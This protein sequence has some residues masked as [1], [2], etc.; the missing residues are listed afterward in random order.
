MARQKGRRRRLPPPSFFARTPRPRVNGPVLPDE[1]VDAKLELYRNGD[2]GFCYNNDVKKI[3]KAVVAAA[4][5]TIGWSAQAGF[6]RPQ[7]TR[8]YLHGPLSERVAV[9]FREGKL[10]L[11]ENIHRDD[12]DA[13][14]Y[15]K[16]TQPAHG[17]WLVHGADD[18]AFDFR[19]AVLNRD[20]DG[21]PVHSQIWR[22]GD[23]EVE[24]AACMPVGLRTSIQA[25]LTVTNR[26]TTPQAESFGFLLRAAPENKLVFGAP[27]IY[28]IYAPDVRDWRQLPSTFRSGA[29][30]TFVDGDR[31]AAFG[32]VPRWDAQ[33]GAVRFAFELAPGA[34]RTVDFAVGKGPAECP[35]FASAAAVV[36]AEWVKLLSRAKNRTPFVRGQVV[37]IL[38]CFGQAKDE[39]FV[40]PRQGGLQRFV[41]PGETV[42]VV[43]ALDRLGYGE[44]GAMAIDFL[45]RFARPDGQIGPFANDWA[46]ETSYVLETL[47]RH[48]LVTG[49]RTCWQ[50]HRAAAWR[51]FEWI[52]A[53]RAET[54]AG[55]DD[56]VAG[57]FPPLK[58]TDSAK[59]FQHWGMTDLANE[60]ALKVFGEAAERLGEPEAAKVRTEWRAYRAV[61]ERVLDRWRL[62]S[63]GRDT[64]FIPLAPD[65]ANEAK[66]RADNFFYLHPGAFAEGGYLTKD[67][68]LRLRTW[69]VR[70][71]I[72]NDAGLYQHHPSSDPTL[73][74]PIWYT[75]WSEYQWSV[76]WRRVGRADL[77]QQSLEA[78]LRWSVTDE[79]YVG[80][81]I[82]EETPWYYPWSP[83]ASGSARLLKMLL[84]EGRTEWK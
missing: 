73:G 56:V 60:H 71:G 5:L 53:K 62:A 40:L 42:H 58:S 77:A 8:R 76:A 34:S 14:R 82:H 64:F 1:T 39:D 22:A 44:Y 45:F 70:E 67:E 50:R 68:M 83:N 55:G 25:R 84:D 66:F 3:L 6:V 2:D 27:D 7:T 75:T 63:S 51:G 23:L 33:A 32:G 17:V 18:A 74:D 20:P 12:W 19:K 59:R 72:A 21:V 54:A 49:D 57:L 69:L 81:R 15:W 65:G 61:I 79:G 41:W 37:Q 46:G 43:E 31:F 26:G 30:V 78:L 24:L 13:M 35:D 9:F 52:V 47:A 38:Q 4:F 28:K 11:G 29:E 36:R 80:E 48:C 10:T 16:G